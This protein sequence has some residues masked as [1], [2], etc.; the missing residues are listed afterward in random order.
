MQ[1]LRNDLVQKY[2]KN[3]YESIH[4]SVTIPPPLNSNLCI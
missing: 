2:K 4:T 3:I 1:N